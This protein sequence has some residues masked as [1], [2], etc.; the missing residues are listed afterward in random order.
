MH[1]D[2]FISSII[3]S[4]LHRVPPNWFLL[5]YWVL[6]CTV[7][8]QDAPWCTELHRDAPIWLY[9][10]YNNFCIALSATK[11]NFYCLLSSCLHRDGFFSSI[12]TSVLHR[13]PRN[14][15]LL[16]YL[17]PICTVM[18]RDAPWCTELHRDVPRWLYFFYNNF[19]IAP[20]ATKLIFITFFS[21]YLHRDAPRCTV[22]HRVA[23]WC[24]EMALFLL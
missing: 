23:P 10:F 1:W 4:E 11:L 6:I 14:W 2:G 15:F 9:F 12:V 5:L 13:V 7:M 22:M 18:K 17:V 3:S 21:S 19:W 20:C 16:L 8:H 24:T